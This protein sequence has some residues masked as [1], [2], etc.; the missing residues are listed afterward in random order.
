MMLN[1]AKTENTAVYPLNTLNFDID[2]I[3]AK[4]HAERAKCLLEDGANQFKQAQGSYSHSKRMLGQT[5]LM[6]GIMG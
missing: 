1:P 2:T 4:Y 5:F 6:I 3:T